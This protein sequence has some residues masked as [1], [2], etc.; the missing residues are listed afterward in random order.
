MSL[1]IVKALFRNEGLSTFSRNEGY[2]ECP[3]YQLMS[4][5]ACSRLSMHQCIGGDLLE[6]L[7][8]RKP[9]LSTYYVT[10]KKEDDQICG[11][12]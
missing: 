6:L 9:T 10:M 5:L 4:P 2:E 8:L 11:E 12:G 1:M 7:P 3:S